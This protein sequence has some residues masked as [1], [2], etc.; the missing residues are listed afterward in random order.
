MDG[1]GLVSALGTGVVAEVDPALD[2]GG[3]EPVAAVEADGVGAALRQGLEADGA[4][5]ALGLDG[6]WE[7]Q[8]GDLEGRLG[9][10]AERVAQVVQRRQVL[11]I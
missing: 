11:F 3:V 6:F 10:F 9:L 2:A 8:D 7:G 1:L 5:V 4:V